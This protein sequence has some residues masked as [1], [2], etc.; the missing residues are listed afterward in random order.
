MGIWTDVVVDQNF[1]E[2][3]LDTIKE[4]TGTGEAAGGTSDFPWVFAIVAGLAV[5]AII[6]IIIRG[7]KEHKAQQK[8]KKKTLY[9]QGYL[10]YRSPN[11]PICTT[12][13]NCDRG[14]FE[15][16]R[17]PLTNRIAIGHNPERC[18]IC[19][20]EG[21]GAGI[22]SEHCEVR[23]RTDG[24]VEIVDLGSMGGTFLE[25]GRRLLSNVPTIIPNGGRFYLVSK[26]EMYRLDIKNMN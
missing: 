12:Y 24:Q 18:N 8:G 14:Y 11:E 4:A 7:I 5:I 10:Q 25:N 22:A 15:G 13:L 23:L 20:P 1:Y 21:R 3:A 2:K 16:R 17:Y 6:V 19:Y 9:E 26:D